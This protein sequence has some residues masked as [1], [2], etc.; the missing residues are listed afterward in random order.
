[1]SVTSSQYP[2]LPCPSSCGSVGPPWGSPATA[3]KSSSL[4]SPQQTGAS[5]WNSQLSTPDG[6]EDCLQAYHVSWLLLAARTVAIFLLHVAQAPEHTPPG[7]GLYG[8]NRGHQL[9]MLSFLS[10]DLSPAARLQQGNCSASP[11]P[12]SL[13]L[14]FEFFL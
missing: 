5:T 7:D 2:K 3:D 12:F 9:G 11:P 14:S 10:A 4:E 1:M 8:E 6:P 13:V